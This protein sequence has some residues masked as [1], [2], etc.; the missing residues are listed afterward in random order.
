MTFG[1]RLREARK[2]AALSQEQLAE[3]MSVSRSA[4]TKYADAIYI[5]VRNKKM[6]KSEWWLD[7]LVQPGI[8][9]LYHL[10]LINPT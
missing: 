6:T 10:R 9:R 1:E 8:S 5:G 3:K 2:E 7:F 4:I